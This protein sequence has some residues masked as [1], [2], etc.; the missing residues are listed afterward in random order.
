M[1][2]F[3]DARLGRGDMMMLHKFFAS[4]PAPRSDISS[5]MFRFCTFCFDEKRQFQLN[6]SN[7]F[8]T[9]CSKYLVLIFFVP[10]GFL[11]LADVT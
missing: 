1:G 3:V 6:P 8:L 5:N 2:F 10:F 9:S 7:S 11:L 4:G